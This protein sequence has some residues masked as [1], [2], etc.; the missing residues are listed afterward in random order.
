MIFD[1]ADRVIEDLIVTVEQL[2]SELALL[3]ERVDALYEG[4]TP[5]APKRLWLSRE[6]IN[7]LSV[8]SAEW[9]SVFQDATRDWGEANLA[10][11]DSQHDVLTYAGAL[12]AVR[13]DDE[14]M[15]NKVVAALQSAMV[16]PLGRALEV[17]RGLQAYIIA[18]DLIGYINPE[19]D[20]WLTHVIELDLRGH[21]GVGIIGTARFSSNNWGNMARAA[22]LIAGLFLGRQDWVDIVVQA[23]SEYI[24]L[25]T[26]VRELKYTSTTWHFDVNNKAGINRKGAV[27]NGVYISGVTPEDWRRDEANLKWPITPTS[28]DYY[29]WEVVQGLIVVATLLDRHNVLSFDAGD[30]AV[31]RVIEMLYG[32]GEANNNTPVVV[33]PATEDDEWIIPLVNM[34]TALNLPYSI[35]K[36]GKGMGYTYW[37]HGG[38]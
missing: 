33:I 9:Q 14:A 20:A 37:T 7:K 32:L 38:R 35:N 5:T 1:E 27:V 12:V 4:V 17:S 30:F 24:G 10:N 18:A 11:N 23:H 22:L 6:E 31:Q 26:A 28:S 2:S 21:S 25:P 8:T 13:L 29:Y 15:R 34:Y 19:F 16:S 3:K 36:P